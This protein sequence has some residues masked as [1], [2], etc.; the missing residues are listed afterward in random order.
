MHYPEILTR[1]KD[2]FQ[3]LK[4]GTSCEKLNILKGH[5]QQIPNIS[6]A[7]KWIDHYAGIVYKGP[8]NG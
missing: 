7:G 8:H 6:A 2:K 5:I 1:V 4:T 3:D